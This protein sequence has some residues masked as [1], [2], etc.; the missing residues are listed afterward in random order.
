MTSFFQRMFPRLF[1]GSTDRRS[2]V[3][4]GQADRRLPEATPEVFRAPSAAVLAAVGARRPLMG[5]DGRIVGFEFRIGDDTQRRLARR[6]DHRGQAAYVSTVLTSAH[7][8]GQYGSMGFARVPMHWMLH[9]EDLSAASGIWVGLEQPA[10]ADLGPE[11]RQA[12]TELV[13]QLR[14][15]DAKVGWDI[16]TAM[17]VQ[18]DFVLLRQGANPMAAILEAVKTWPTALRELPLVLTDMASAEDIE[19]ALLSGVRYVCGALTPL[20]VVSEAKEVLPVPPGVR[21]VGHLLNQLVCGA[22]TAAIVSEIKGDVGL[23]YRLLRL[24]NSASFAQLQAGDS[25]DHAVQMLGRQELYRWL[26]L[27]LIQYAG[28]SKMSSAL[29][30]IA[31]W[32]SR[33][34]ELLAIEQRE[35]APNQLFTLGLA[36]ML[37]LILHM[38]LADVVETLSLSEPAH[39]ALIDETGPW[40]I[41]LQLAF[42]VEAQQLDA[43]DRLVVQFGGLERVLALS[44]QAWTWAS[45]HSKPVG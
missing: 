20:G 11:A 8:I 22:D 35:E 6:T 28:K 15:L 14:A 7:L 40:R 38:S 29:Q 21:R 43:S 41:Y 17:D 16:T 2:S 18:P 36:S 24:L 27:M 30:E 23:S 3:R 45:E 33:L 5:T 44:D 10:N 1:E 26:S 12:V 19:Q 13:R 34:L 31:L 39:Q 4:P 25:I 42:L 37:G 32:R 9:C